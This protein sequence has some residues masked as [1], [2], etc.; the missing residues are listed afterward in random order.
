MARNLRGYSELEFLTAVERGDVVT[1]RSLSKRIGVAVGLI[2]ALIKRSTVK[3][4]VKARQAPYKRYAYYLTPEGF[5]EKSRLVGEYLQSSLEFFRKARNQYSEIFQAAARNGTKRL[6]IVGG[7]ELAD[8]AVLAATSE[9]VPLVAIIDPRARE[10]SDR[11]GVAVKRSL[12]DIE[13]VDLVVIADEQCPQAI[14]EELRKSLS[15]DRIM[16]PPLLHITPDRDELIMAAAS[17]DKR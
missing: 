8:I 10:T 17:G 9:G 7:G 3:G 14:Y 1:Q 2:N 6:A 16:T 11:F 4:Y 13:P 12:A 5:A 15:D